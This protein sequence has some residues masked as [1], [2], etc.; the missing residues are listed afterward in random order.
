MCSWWLSSREYGEQCAIYMWSQ[1]CSPTFYY[2]KFHQ[3]VGGGSS[4]TGRA[5][6]YWIASCPSMLLHVLFREQLFVLAMELAL[7]FLCTPHWLRSLLVLG[8]FVQVGA[9]GGQPCYGHSDNFCVVTVVKF[10]ELLWIPLMG[11]VTVAPGNATG[12]LRRCIWNCASLIQADSSWYIFSFQC[13][14]PN[15]YG[16]SLP[17]KSQHRHVASSYQHNGTM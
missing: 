2:C 10:A 1:P 5:M 14:L 11:N 4:L 6:A 7:R 13:P 16:L 15:H 9:A 8:H 12:Q 3:T 17:F